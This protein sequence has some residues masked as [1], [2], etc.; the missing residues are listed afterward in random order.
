MKT[1]FA[2][3]LVFAFLAVNYTLRD[4]LLAAQG[5]WWAAGALGATA[6]WF[7]IQR[8]RTE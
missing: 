2:F 8:E 4:E 6:F 1:T 7:A 3:A 5:A